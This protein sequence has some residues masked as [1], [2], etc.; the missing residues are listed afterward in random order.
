MTHGD[1]SAFVLAAAVLIALVPGAGRARGQEPGPLPNGENPAQVATLVAFFAHT[2]QERLLVSRSPRGV[3]LRGRLVDAGGAGVRS[4]LIDVRMKVMT[5]WSPSTFPPALRTAADGSFTVWVPSRRASRRVDLSYRPDL[6][7]LHVAAS[8][9]LALRVRAALTLRLSPRVVPR[10][11]TLRF[12]GHLL[13]GPLPPLGK[14]VEL[15]AR[16]AGT[17]R[18]L[19]F[20]TVRVRGRGGRFAARHRFRRARGPL[21]LEFRARARADDAYPFAT[22]SSRP[23]RVR[24]R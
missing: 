8:H 22:G 7:S 2:G 15:Q 20:R 13:G 3:T 9:T 14:I 4:A 12:A 24:V 5:P 16:D 19:T 11:G 21:T 18:W 23:V 17:L 6:G 1:R 10:G